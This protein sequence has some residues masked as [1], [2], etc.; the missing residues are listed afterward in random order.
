MSKNT[1]AMDGYIN[2][3]CIELFRYIFHDKLGYEDDKLY[4]DINTY[5][6]NKRE[7]I[8]CANETQWFIK[9]Y[10]YLG[11]RKEIYCPMD[12]LNKLLI[13]EQM[14]KTLLPNVTIQIYNSDTDNMKN[15]NINNLWNQCQLL[16]YNSVIQNGINFDVN[17]FEYCFTYGNSMSNTVR[18]SM[19]MI[20]RVRNISSNQVYY[21]N[22]T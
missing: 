11:Q 15:T 13:Y 14:V 8:S 17:Y 19:Q 10:Q 6:L 21:Y 9:L 22:K 20:M 1:I 4:L 3:N 18:N 16:I 7:Y 5:K 12:S 2:P